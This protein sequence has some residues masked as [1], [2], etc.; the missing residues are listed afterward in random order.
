[1]KKTIAILLTLTM[2]LGMALTGCAGK[3]KEMT[4]AVE[5]GSAGEAVA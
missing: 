4:Y 3:D 2:V 1:M 5:A